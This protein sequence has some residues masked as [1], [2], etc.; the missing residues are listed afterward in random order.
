H[1]MPPGKRKLTKDEIAVIER[2]IAQGTKTEFPEPKALA[3]GFHITAK[4]QAF[5]SFQPIRR[6]PAPRVRAQQLV[7][8]PIDAF[9]L[10]KL[11][12]K[13]LSF[14][15]EADKRTL[16]RRL[17]F[18]LTGL[19]PTPKEVD[20]FLADRSADAYERQVDRL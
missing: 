13:G 1:E 14:S 19:P 5:W 12:E 9:L 15:A 17:T 8:T 4:E 10:A 18:D 7:R 16:L 2:W 20:D 3:A 6:P 11:E